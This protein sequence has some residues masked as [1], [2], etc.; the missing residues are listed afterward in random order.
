MMLCHSLEPRR[1]MASSPLITGSVVDAYRLPDNTVAHVGLADRTVYVD[2]NNNGALDAGEVSTTTD[3]AGA[4]K[5]SP[6]L[7]TD[8]IRLVERSGWSVAGI[9]SITKTIGRGTTRIPVFST[10]MTHPT[11]VDVLALYTSASRGGKDSHATAAQI[12]DLFLQANQVYANSDTNVVLNYVAITAT[13]YRESGS[14]DDD[15]DALGDGTGALAKVPELRDTDYADIV[16]MFTSGAKTP[17]DSIGIGYEYDPTDTTPAETGFNVVAIQNDGVDND[18]FTL[19]HEIGHNLGAGH[20]KPDNDGPGVTAYAYGY[21]YRGTNGRLYQD[22]MDYSDGI[23]L[24]FFS[25]PDFF[26]AGKPIGNA[27]SAD[28]ARIVRL[29]APNVAAYE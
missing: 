21:H 20:D 23:A 22:V 11:R 19:A 5:L 28:N 2:T 29:E 18:A 25:T 26:W 10:R 7:G 6:P 12:R 4:Y 14:I 9:D 8:T 1:L 16:T 24:P 15:L 27:S 3:L 17:G 13:R